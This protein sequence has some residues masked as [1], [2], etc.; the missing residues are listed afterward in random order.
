VKN[1]SVSKS[2]TVLIFVTTVIVGFILFALPNLFFGIFK[3]YG[4]L[5]GTNLIIIAIFQLLSI[6]TLIFFSLKSLNKDIA[7]IGISLKHWKRDIFIGL[8]ITLIRLVID[9]GFIIPGTGGANRPDILEVINSLDGTSLGLASLIFLGIVGGGIAE[10]IY[11]RGFFIKVFKDLFRNRKVGVI[12]ASLLSILFFSFAHMPTSSLL[13]Y[14]ILV[15]SI[16]YTG[17][18]LYTGRLT[19]SIV[20]HGVWNMLAILIINYAY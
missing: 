1:Q 18:F 5:S 12:L 7:Y 2:R 13:W 10:E 19:A 3:S 8:S 4:G 16:I 14:D 20:A 15:A 6:F 11:Y 9:F 17:L